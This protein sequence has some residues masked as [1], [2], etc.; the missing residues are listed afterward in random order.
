MRFVLKCNICIK[1]VDYYLYMLDFD[2]SFTESKT[3]AKIKKRGTNMKVLNYILNI[4]SRHFA[5]IRAFSKGKIITRI[6]AIFLELLF[7]AATLAVEFWAISLFE[8][9]PLTALIIGILLLLPL[10]AVT[11]EYCLLYCY[12]GF[13]SFVSGSLDSLVSKIEAKKKKKKK[14]EGIIE[15]VPLEPEQAP[16]QKKS[17]KWLDLIVAILSLLFFIGTLVLAVSLIFN[18]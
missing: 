11:L 3:Y 7:I 1:K 13:R 18:K 5:E 14:D 6:L 9:E 17:R 12:I 16:E 2:L 4:E 10:F 8:T 15:Q